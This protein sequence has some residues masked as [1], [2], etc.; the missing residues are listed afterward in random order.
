MVEI[1]DGHGISPTQKV[2]LLTR[3]RWIP[4]WIQFHRWVEEKDIRAAK[5]RITGIYQRH[6]RRQ[7]CTFG[8]RNAHTIV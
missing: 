3:N 6:S 5:H 7:I 8:E 1:I 4:P 2:K